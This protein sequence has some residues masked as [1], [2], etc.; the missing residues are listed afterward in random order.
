MRP[1]SLNSPCRAPSSP[2]K[3]ASARGLGDAG[4]ERAGSRAGQAPNRPQPQSGPEGGAA[5]G[6][7]GA[8]RGG[9][10]R[11][12]REEARG[13]LGCHRQPAPAGNGRLFPA[14]RP[15]ATDPEPA[16]GVGVATRCGAGGKPLGRGQLRS[17]PAWLQLH[18]LWSATAAVAVSASASIVVGGGAARTPGS[19]PRNEAR[20][21][22]PALRPGLEP[23]PE[24]REGNGDPSPDTLPIF[25]PLLP[26]LQRPKLCV[27]ELHCPLSL[28]RLHLKPSPLSTALCL[29]P[30]FRLHANLSPASR[31]P[32]PG[33]WFLS[34]PELCWAVWIVPSCQL[35]FGRGMA[36]F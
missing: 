20:R 23:C 26:P 31:A 28:M 19:L 16:A 6:R 8:G 1:Q 30:T 22:G 34:L 2:L 9:A 12:G 18:L 7:G 32:S 35:D 36:E 13:R 27:V 21:P 29:V 24:S 17:V 10:D 15:K 3:S 4:Q 11:V 5:A 33:R 25:P 14:G